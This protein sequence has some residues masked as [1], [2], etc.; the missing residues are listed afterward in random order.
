M[1]DSVVTVLFGYFSITSAFLAAGYLV[2]PSLPKV[3]RRTIVGLYSFM[4]LTLIA[5]CERYVQSLIILRD[6][7]REGASWHVA[8]SD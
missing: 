6:L 3:L 7:M 8:V 4:A 1:A 2:G 5:W